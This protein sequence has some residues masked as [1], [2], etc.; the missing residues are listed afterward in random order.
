ME[1]IKPVVSEEFEFENRLKH[2]LKAFLE[3]SDDQEYDKRI[4]T[5]CFLIKSSSTNAKF[6][7]ETPK[8]EIKPVVAQKIEFEDRVTSMKVAFFAFFVPS[9]L[10]RK[11]KSHWFSLEYS[12]R[13]SHWNLS[14]RVSLLFG[15]M[16]VATSKK[17]NANCAFW[18]S[19]NVGVAKLCYRRSSFDVEML[20]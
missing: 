1:G 3:S 11:A 17:F 16:W 5:K 4:K 18:Y 7:T 9:W 6:S 8:E 19:F 14:E 2:I 12:F 10:W 15:E 13:A 20:F